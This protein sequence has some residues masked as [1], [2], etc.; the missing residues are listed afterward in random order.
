MSRRLS[1]STHVASMNATSPVAPSIKTLCLLVLPLLGIGNAVAADEK[2]EIT[3]SVEVTGMPFQMPATVLTLCAPPGEMHDDKMIP[4]Q[5]GCKV[6]Q[7]SKSGNT[8]RFKMSCPPPQ[9]MTGEGEITQ[10]GKDAYRGSMTAKGV[11]EGRATEM[12]T[13][14]A[15]RKL[16]A[17]DG[18][19]LNAG[20]AMGAVPPSGAASVSPQGA[21]GTPGAAGLPPG[22]RFEGKEVDQKKLL[23][24]L[25]KM[26]EMYG[27]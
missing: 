17:C 15:G 27:R 26:K 13:T 12:K 9:A 8:T 7:M 4:E 3:T 23:E 18:T 25:Q 11:I 2:W 6:T 10:T 19:E 5:N 22:I 21:A 16:G 24:G 1:A 20:A 14:Y